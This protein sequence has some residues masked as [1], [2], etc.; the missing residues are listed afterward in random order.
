MRKSITLA[1][2]MALIPALSAVAVA[3][4]PMMMKTDRPVEAQLEML[5]EQSDAQTPPAVLEAGRLGTE[6]LIQADFAGGALN[7]GDK[8]PAFRL[9]DA[10]GKSWNSSDL[11]KDGP[12]VLVFY[13]GAWCPFCNLYLRSVQQYLPQFVHQTEQPWPT[14]DQPSN[15]HSYLDQMLLQP[16]PDRP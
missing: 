5:K 13:R 2:G 3:D 1:A 9:A 14:H 15:Q 7:R 16:R 12:I 4:D 8:M 6:E 10:H 11:I